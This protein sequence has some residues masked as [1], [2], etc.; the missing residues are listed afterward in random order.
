MDGQPDELVR[1]ARAVEVL[2]EP[3]NLEVPGLAGNVGDLHGDLARPENEQ[4][5][6]AHGV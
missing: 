3:G 5:L 2:H 1:A 6:Q 4:R